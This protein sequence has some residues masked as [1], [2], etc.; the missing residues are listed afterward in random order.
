MVSRLGLK[1]DC[2]RT[3]LQFAVA[4]KLAG[5]EIIEWRVDVVEVGPNQPVSYTHATSYGYRQPVVT[6]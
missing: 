4:R 6:N 1:R 2:K 5:G 3:F